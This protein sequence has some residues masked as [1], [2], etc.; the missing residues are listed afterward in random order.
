MSLYDIWNE[1]KN[2]IFPF[3]TPRI[4]GKEIMSNELKALFK[5]EVA[6]LQTCKVSAMIVNLLNEFTSETMKDLSL[7]DHAIDCLIVIL[8]DEKTKPSV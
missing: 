3:K 1:I 7:K 2:G 5:K 8:Q 6:L 4:T